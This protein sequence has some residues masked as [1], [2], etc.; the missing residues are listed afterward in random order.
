[1][2]LP[3][4]IHLLEGSLASYSVLLTYPLANALNLDAHSPFPIFGGWSLNKVSGTPG[5]ATG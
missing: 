2:H 3:A 5:F 4:P 1:M